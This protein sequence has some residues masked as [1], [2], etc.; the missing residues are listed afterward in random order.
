MT[1]TAVMPRAYRNLINGEWVEASTGR[2]FENRNPAN[3]DEL[4]GMFPASA[5]DDV[6]QTVKATQATYKK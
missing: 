1:S 4:I 6:N 3:A 5:E 2:F